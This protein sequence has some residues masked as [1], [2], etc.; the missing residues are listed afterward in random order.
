MKA[1]NPNKKGITKWHLV[2]FV[3]IASSLI[4]VSC[5]R[6]YGLSVT[7]YDTIVTVYDKNFN[8]KVNKNFAMPD[9][10]LHL[11]GENEEDNISR[12]YDDLM[13]STVATNMTNYGYTRVPF[14]TTQAAPDLVVLVS[15]A[16][17]TWRGYTWSPGWGY[18]GGWGWWGWG[19]GYGGYYPGYA[20]PYEFETGT[21]IIEL[22]DPDEENPNNQT[23]AQIIWNG[24]IN[25]LLANTTVG[26]SSRISTNIDNAYKQSPYLNVK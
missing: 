3:L 4:V 23:E 12:Q 2:I 25:G 19:P 9:T 26:T 20:V 17:Q 15:V 8:Y 13:L 11:L 14:D 22:L 24:G 7:D 21:I 5:Y 16:S 10:V 1:F 18:W 6:D